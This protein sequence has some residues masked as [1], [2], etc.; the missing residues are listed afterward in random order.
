[1]K[2][3][4]KIDIVLLMCVIGLMLFSIGAVYSASVAVAG[5]KH[6]DAAFLFKNHSIRV[7]LGLVALFIGMNVDYHQYAKLSKAG[8]LVAL[9]LLAFTVFAG[10]TLNG[11]QRWIS[12]GPIQ[13]QPSEFAKYAL[14]I[15]LAVLLSDKQE[16]IN[17]FM[18]GYVPLLVWVSLVVFA[19]FMQPNFS[20]GAIVF[21]VSIMLMYTGRVNIKH[22]AATIAMVIPAVVVYAISA[23]YRWNRIMAFISSS[24]EGSD[25]VD[26]AKYQAQQAVIGLGSGGLLGVG[27]GLSKQRELFLP[28]SYTDFIFAIIGEEYGLVGT[29]LILCVFCVILIRG[30]KIAKHAKDDLGRFIAIG[31]TIVISMYALINAM[32]TTGLTPTTGL[33]MPLVSY[34]G[35]SILITCYAFGILLNVS[36][37][38]SDNRKSAPVNVA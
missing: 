27:M 34:G 20:T 38:N 33:P 16:Y 15:H 3:E 31:I 23:P 32:V 14:V 8:I 36:R 6:G 1:M 24:D 13:F 9:I 18:K 19:I 2:R 30:V 21:L 22:I 12:Y 5:A 4:N 25:V 17:D 11:A 7:M 10:V 28:E 37:G 26:A 29:W 35:T